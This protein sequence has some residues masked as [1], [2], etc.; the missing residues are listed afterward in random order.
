MDC[1]NRRFRS[2]FHSVARGLAAASCA[3]LFALGQAAAQT[4][5]RCDL[6]LTSTPGAA[7]GTACL[8]LVA[9][10]N[11][12]APIVTAD[13]ATRISVDGFKLCKNAFEVSK[14]AGADIVFIYDNS[15]SMVPGYVK[16]DAASGD[17]TFYHIT[18]CTRATGTPFT[19]NTLLSPRTIQLV[20][21][22]ANCQSNSLAGDPYFARGKA[23]EKAVD[24]LV[25]NSPTSTVGAMSFAD[26]VANIRPPLQ[27]SL[28]GNA[29]S[30][31]LSIHLDSIRN[32]LYLPPL[33]QA[34]KWLTDP[35][36]IKN[37]KQAM[38]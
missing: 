26:A 33:N 28:P 24:Y 20:D 8:D 14:P 31:K 36:Y 1:T 27:L 18:G 22:A 13:N 2:D 19:Y 17:S 32:T 3:A 16:I 35:A 6:Q 4:P 38:I 29:D 5:L 25:A 9:L 11:G 34:R 12:G 37:S 23:I 30:V 15:G 21:A 7:A 10:Q